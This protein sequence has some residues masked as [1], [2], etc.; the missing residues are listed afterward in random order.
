MIVVA[1]SMVGSL[2]VLP[3]LLG[4]LE[5]RVDRGIL[6]VFAATLLRIGRLFKWQPRALVRLRERRTLL[7]RL[8]GDRQES[9][10]W[11]FVLSK[12]M[13]FPAISAALATALLVVMEMPVIGLRTMLLSVTALPSRQALGTT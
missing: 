3:A 13:R 5:D 8:K 2:T 7:Q 10:V 12:T 1:V 6:A 4:K 9:R 11:G